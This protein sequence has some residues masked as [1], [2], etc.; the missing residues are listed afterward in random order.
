ML[1]EQA[2]VAA[3][4]D[5]AIRDTHRL[6]ALRRTALLD[7]DP[8]EAFDRLTRL[9]ATILR[10]PSALV[11]LVDADRQFS[12]S[13]FGLAEPL[14][15]ERQTP[16]SHSFCQHTVASGA[17]LI[18]ADAREHPL[19][20]DNPA[21]PDFGVVA[22]AG[23]PLVTPDGYVLGSFCVI[24][25][26]PRAWTAQDI[27]IL[28][29]LAAAVMTEIDL[30][31]TAREATV[32]AA[33]REE[34][35][36]RAREAQAQAEAAVRLRNDFLTVAAHDLRTP[37]T[38][39][40]GRIQLV[41]RRLT[42]GKDVDPPWLETQLE[43]LSASTKRMLATVSELGDMARVQM[44]EALELELEDVDLAV[45][46]RVVVDEATLG[47]GAHGVEATPIVLDAPE[48]PVTARGDSA[49][50]QRVLHNIV[51]NAM[52]YSPRGA[53]VFVGVRERD[54]D[55]AITVRDEGV[56]IPANELP[57]IF[58]RYYRASTARGIA[59]SGIGLSGAKAIVE[60][61]DGVLSIES[62]EGRGT[63]VTI[64]LPRALSLS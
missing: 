39:M 11:S 7:S 34:L 59:G 18:I 43:S 17:P 5:A 31:M 61:H 2:P 62:G 42:R 12:K 4:V 50:L 1:L 6:D 32:R 63:T 28:T 55:V 20:R 14:A 37:L 29:D 58:T 33:E 24:D 44:G 36:A 25:Y 13:A 19:V 3:P 9:A 51:G 52:K 48:T 22:Y 64:V 23:I 49:R 54:S 10:A 47:L 26:Q 38:N 40:L 30:R 46:A 60:Q 35:L 16:L 41:E 8:E 53:P 21:I 45:L 57:R 15:S 27:A 56:G